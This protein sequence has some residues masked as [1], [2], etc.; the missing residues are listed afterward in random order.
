ML[1]A[2]FLMAAIA[3][4]PTPTPSPAVSSSTSG[5]VSSDY[6]EARDSGIEAA[7]LVGVFC[8]GFVVAVKV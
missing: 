6:I 7:V 2:G 8:A 3:T 4:S 1:I 5:P